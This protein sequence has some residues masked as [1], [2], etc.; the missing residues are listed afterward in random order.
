MLQY[1]LVCNRCGFEEG[2]EGPVWDDWFVPRTC[3][4]PSPE[5]VCNGTMLRVPVIRDS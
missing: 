4:R 1:A 3:G 2:H 5:G